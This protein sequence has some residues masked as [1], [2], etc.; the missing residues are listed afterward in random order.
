MNNLSIFL[1]NISIFIIRNER[2]QFVLII[3]AIL[4]IFFW[5]LIF[6]GE[7]FSPADMLYNYYPWK[8]L[9]PSNFLPW[10]DLRSDDAFMF[11]PNLFFIWNSIKE[12]YLPLWNPFTL[13]G[14]PTF[15]LDHM[16]VFYPLKFPYLIFPMAKAHGIFAFVLLLSGGWFMYLFLSKLGIKHF[17]ALIGSV[18]FMLN[19][20]FVVW[21][22]AAIPMVGIF[23]PLALL[24]IESLFQKPGVKYVLLLGFSIGAAL[25]VGHIPSS[26]IFITVIGSY[27]LFKLFISGASKRIRLIGLFL[28]S[29]LI[30]VLLSAS[31]IIPIYVYYINSTTIMGRTG[32]LTHFNVPDN[33]I[34]YLIPDFW[35]N[36]IYHNWWAA[37]GNYCE[38]IS[39]FGVLP[40]FLVGFAVIYCRK[41]L[42]VLFFTLLALFS[43]GYAYGMP[44]INLIGHLPG[45]MQSG[46]L[47][48]V[49]ASNFSFAILAGFGADFI[50]NRVNIHESKKKLA[51]LTLI[52]GGIILLGLILIYS[53]YL[54][55]YSKSLAFPFKDITINNY[56]A[57]SILSFC[58]LWLFVLILS[59]YKNFNNSLVI[60]TSFFIFI[61]FYYYTLNIISNH[62][63]SLAKFQIINITKFL[64]LFLLGIL[65]LL[66][67]FKGAYKE[68]FFKTVL[69]VLITLDLLAFSINFNPTIKSEDLYPVTDGISF[70]KNDNEYFRIAPVGNL[71]EIFPGDTS[72]LYGFSTILGFDIIANNEYQKFL[73]S[74]AVAELNSKNPYLASLRDTESIN[75]PLLD[76]LNVK[77]VLITPKNLT[78]N[79]ISQKKNSKSVG[80]IYGTVKVGQTFISEHNNLT[81]IDVLLATNGNELGNQDII[82]HLK[83]KPLDPKDIVAIKINASNV[84]DNTYYSFDFPPIY[85]SEGKN[86]YFYIESPTS[87]IG[88]AITIWATDNDAYKN[89][90]LYQNDFP[91]IDDLNFITY[92]EN[93]KKFELVYKGNDLY[94][95]K[96]KE[97]LPRAWIVHKAII[98]NNSNI[99][100]HMQ[101]NEFDARSQVVLGDDIPQNIIN[102]LKSTSDQSSVKFIYY[103]PNSIKLH[104]DMKN[105][106]FLVLSERYA[107]DWKAFANEKE[108]KIYKADYLL[109][110][111][112]LEEGEYEVKFLYDPIYVKFGFYSTILTYLFIIGTIGFIERNNFFRLIGKMR[113]LKGV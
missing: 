80:E 26:I 90:S 84:F 11:Y 100:S 47:R 71:L 37:Q 7:S 106:G 94:I 38:W 72:L 110:A 54:L 108:I 57:I 83:N 88:N 60:S 97:Y 22:S 79:D 20:V 75:S 67:Y 61:V 43:L 99:L 32:G 14:S 59:Y 9:A 29:I 16:G 23:L 3:I 113:S 91:S 77:Y 112:Y 21:L 5:R 51:K 50:T 18:T 2:T 63:L 62:N 8:S 52:I 12:G 95:Y 40:I 31:E 69:L 25:L 109:R 33:L 56:I 107:Q 104:V 28:G 103:L 64:F 55:I 1:K 92:Y 36:P 105:P 34:N 66:Q 78:F 24:F 86:F 45:F 58:L 89:G 48:W 68:N 53:K 76:L 15:L 30:A 87:S 81:R 6:L 42:H 102:D 96:N 27:F 70:L 49:L 17:G 101:S 13:S 73:D 98:Q 35:G 41:N 93:L 19:G 85:N 65:T 46:A 74:M 82:F 4:T 111:V 10:N 44:V 39:Y